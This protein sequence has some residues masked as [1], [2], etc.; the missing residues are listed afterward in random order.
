M[1]RPPRGRLSV[2]RPDDGLQSIALSSD[3]LAADSARG[4]ADHIR[5]V[6]KSSA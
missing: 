4:S 3:D 5:L 1:F 6:A 2:V